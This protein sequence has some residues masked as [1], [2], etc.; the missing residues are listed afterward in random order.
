MAKGN[1]HREAVEVTGYKEFVRALEQA[2]RKIATKSIRTAEKAGANVVAQ[3]AKTEVPV[4]TGKLKRSVRAGASSKK[5][6]IVRAGNKTSVLY[7]KP[8]HFGWAERGIRPQP[9][10]Y[11]AM[12]ARRDEVLETF[13]KEIEGQFAYH[14]LA[15]GKKGNQNPFGF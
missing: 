7:A 12:D 8:I 2:D 13:Q 15:T 1:F 6:G 11:K 9:F 3:Q 5:G 4:R 10:I 14:G